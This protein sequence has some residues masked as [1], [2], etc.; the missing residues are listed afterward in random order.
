MPLPLP[1]PLPLPPRAGVQVAKLLQERG[2]IVLIADS[3]GVR[4][5]VSADGRD[6]LDARTPLSLWVNRGTAS[7]S[8]VRYGLARVI[9]RPSPVTGWCLCAA[10]FAGGGTQDS[11]RG[12]A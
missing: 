7:A 5:I 3:E 4:D 8:E 11:C 1:L 9:H 2:D 12:N 10:A 6:T